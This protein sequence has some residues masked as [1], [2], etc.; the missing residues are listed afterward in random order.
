MSKSG[1]FQDVL[2]ECLERLLVKNET[3]EQCLQSFPQYSDRL[4]PLLEM[5]LAA[6]RVSDIQPAPE[7]RERARQEFQSALQFRDRARQ[8][9][10]SAL[11]QTGRQKSR[12]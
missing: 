5:A 9:F 7:F 12:V 10:Q 8:E 4:K 3:V 2:D 6:R 1:K 11:Q